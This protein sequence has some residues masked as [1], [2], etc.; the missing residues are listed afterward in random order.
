MSPQNIDSSANITSGKNDKN[1]VREYFNSKGFERWQKIYGDGPV[2][3]VQQSI[4]T[5][6]QQTVDTVLKWLGEDLSGVSICDAGCGLGSLSL[7]LAERGAQV[8]GF[9]IS[10]KMIGEAIQI[11][12][13]ACTSSHNPHFEVREVEAITGKYDAVICLDVLIHYPLEDVEIMLAHLSS[14]SRSR[15]LLTFAPKTPFL[16][17]L[18]K[19]GGFFPGASKT[20][21]AYQHRE[22]DIL[23][24]L[25]K[26]GWT[27]SNRAAIDDK[28]YFARLF[29]AKR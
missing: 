29:E 15:L 7:P 24:I 13:T 5:G 21:R 25:Q 18:K 23:A 14:L 8:S 9:D 19:V 10:E 27:L 17:I 3:R 20:T 4:R 6:H 22:K 16:T 11:R 28:F 12:N 1:I 2:N 26:L